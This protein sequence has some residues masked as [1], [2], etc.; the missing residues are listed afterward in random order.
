MGDSDNQKV[1]VWARG[2]LGQKVGGGECWDFAEGALKEAGAT[3]SEKLGSKGP[4]K[5][6]VWGDPVALT[7]IRPGDILQFKD[8]VVV[9]RIQTSIAFNDG[10]TLSGEQRER[11]SRG[12]HTAIVDHVVDG[13]TLRILEQHVKPLGDKVQV[14]EIPMSGQTVTKVTHETREDTHGNPK[15]GKVTV[16]KIIKVTG[17]FIAYRPKPKQ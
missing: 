1:L 17:S 16:T 11:T 2:R 9:T 10:S 14:H 6:Y 4:N 8:F 5:Q 15:P 13:N 7:D 12:H 3:S